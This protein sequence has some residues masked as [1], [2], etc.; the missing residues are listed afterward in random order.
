[1]II[2][3]VYL[4]I[5]VF[6]GKKSFENTQ[7]LDCKKGYEIQI[8]ETRMS[9][10][11]HYHKVLKNAI[12]IY[13]L[14]FFLKIICHVRDRRTWEGFFFLCAFWRPFKSYKCVWNKFSSHM[15]SSHSILPKLPL[16]QAKNNLASQLECRKTVIS[17]AWETSKYHLYMHI[18]L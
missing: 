14:S 18:G 9:A 5:C 8:H 12:I 10:C 7:D 6:I 1:M 2:N 13:T 11:M 4:S 3:A 17:T 16:K 15:N